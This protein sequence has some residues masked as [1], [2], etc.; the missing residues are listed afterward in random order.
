MSELLVSVRSSSEA[1][2]ALQ[3]GAAVI[4]VKEPTRGSLG[5]AEES[6]TEEIIK[7]VAGR[8]PVSAALGELL[9]TSALSVRPGL[10]YAKLG[11]SGCGRRVHWRRELARASAQMQRAN[12][13]CRPVAVAYADWRRAL[14]PPASDV[15]A[16][17]CGHGFTVLL[18]D[19]WRKDGTTLLN[20]LP[21]TSIVELASCCRDA[22]VR[23]ALAGSLGLE[24][25][26]LLRPVHPDWFAVRGAACRGSVRAGTIDLARVRCLVNLV[27]TS[28][29]DPICGS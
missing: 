26:R 10:T 9:Q 21:M 24:Q 25:I 22:G 7:W 23:I 2:I 1:E 5:R 29:L 18:L 19:T 4:D 12:S 16:F 13:S 20:W 11:L 3:G 27:S 14:A 8:K 17:A 28:V 15:C 6:I